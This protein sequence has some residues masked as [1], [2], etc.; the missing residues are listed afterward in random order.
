LFVA[1]SL[2]RTV[3]EPPRGAQSRLDLDAQPDGLAHEVAKRRGIDPDPEL[4]LTEDP[5]R[6]GLMHAIRYTLRIPTNRLLIAGSALGY[7]FL[8]GLQTFA[9]LFVRGHYHTRQTTAELV[10]ALLVVGAV[11]GTLIAG[12]LTDTLLRRGMLGARVYVPAICCVGAAGL[13]IP[14]LVSS[15]LLPAI[16]FDVAGAALLS[17]ANPGL[18]AARLDIMPARL[19][20]RAE[21]ARTFLR[22][23]AQAIAPIAFGGVSDLIAGIAP[24]QVP[25][26]VHPGVI[27]AS[28]A[29][30]LEIAF[31]IMLATLGAASIVLFRARKTYPRDVATAAASQ[32][33]EPQAA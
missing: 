2:W 8:S 30:G 18:D 20:G 25:V 5:D 4:V 32:L 28:E 12:R 15:R 33:A 16:W 21:S 26:G 9:V 17:G 7:F 29:R 13:L 27:S 1:R 11:A 6:I 23:L 22:S 10:L 24:A 31:L 3:P 19:W 14:G